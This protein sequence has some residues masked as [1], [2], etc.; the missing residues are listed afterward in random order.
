MSIN[1]GNGY[2]GMSAAGIMMYKR[3][4][5]QKLPSTAASSERKRTPHGPNATP[6]APFA[7]THF[8]SIPPPPSAPRDHMSLLQSGY[9]SASSFILPEYQS[10]SAAVGRAASA[11]GVPAPPSM[12]M[13]GMHQQLNQINGGSVYY[14]GRGQQRTDTSSLYSNAP[15]GGAGMVLNNNMSNSEQYHN[16]QS[17]DRNS[18]SRNVPQSETARDNLNQNQHSSSSDSNEYVRLPKDHPLAIM[19]TQMQQQQQLERE[20]Q[21]IALLQKYHQQQLAEIQQHQQRF[22][23]S[24]HQTG[25]PFPQRLQGFLNETSYKMPESLMQQQINYQAI[26]QQHQFQQ[27]NQKKM[28]GFMAGGRHLPMKHDFLQPNNTKS[29]LNSDNDALHCVEALL[30]FRGNEKDNSSEDHETDDDEG[31]SGKKKYDK[32]GEKRKRYGTYAC[33]VWNELPNPDHRLPEEVVDPSD[34]E[35]G[36][37]KFS[38]E[39]MAAMIPCTFKKNDSRGKRINLPVG[40]PGLCCRY[41]LGGKEAEQSVTK[42]G[43]FFPASIKTM[44]DTAKS[45]MA[46]YRHLVKCDDCPLIVKERMERFMLTHESERRRRAYGSQKQFYTRIWYRLH[47]RLPPGGSKTLDKK[48]P[49]LEDGDPALL[50]HDKFS[51]LKCMSEVLNPSPSKSET[52]HETPDNTGILIN[53]SSGNIQQSNAANDDDDDPN[54]QVNSAI[55]YYDSIGLTGQSE[56]GA[57]T[58]ENVSDN[59]GSI[60]QTT[61]V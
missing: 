55:E 13:N 45:L 56:Y 15:G 8:D 53:D 49:L 24:N 26:Q 4:E 22:G 2:T 46:I 5:Q 58:S 34:H 10:S 48:F 32:S 44:A 30:Q 40:F 17:G 3:L 41:C 43:R 57:I 6:T 54:R 19:Y 60:K 29:M 16:F 52:D 42:T 59:M 25:D 50:R 11:A 51:K 1:F 14:D 47:G 20:R 27:Q 31:H 61:I 18:N 23:G 7:T 38:Y 9:T 33:Q 37:T 35:Y 36:A 12:Q 21:Q 39:V 28:M